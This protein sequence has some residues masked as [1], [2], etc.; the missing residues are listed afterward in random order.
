[1]PCSR[2]ISFRACTCVFRTRIMLK[3]CNLLPL[4]QN[5]L[6]K[7]HVVLGNADT[8]FQTATHHP[9]T[10]TAI[11]VRERCAYLIS[12]KDFLVRE[13]ISAAR[14]TISRS[15][16]KEAK[17]PPQQSMLRSEHNSDACY[18]YCTPETLHLPVTRDIF[19]EYSY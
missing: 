17:F 10:R 1:V 8:M 12:L 4:V 6:I 19:N 18:D 14:L 2:F 13:S 9:S 16:H 15:A 11:H 7:T 3:T 5:T